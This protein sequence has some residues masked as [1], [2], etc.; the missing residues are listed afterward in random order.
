[1]IP[2]RGRISA[3]HQVLPRYSPRDAIGSE[4][5]LIQALLKKNGIGGEIFYDEG[6]DHEISRPLDHLKPADDQS[7]IC[8]Y[9]FSVGS[10][11]PFKLLELRYRIWSR[12]HN[13]TPGYFFNKP[14]ERPAQTACNLGRRQIPIVS[15]LSEVVLADSAFNLS[16]MAGHTSAKTSVIPV[17]RDYDLLLGKARQSQKFIKDDGKKNI[18]FVGR[19]C[20]NKAQHDLIELIGLDKKFGTKNTRLILVGSFYSHD[21]RDAITSF[22]RDLELKVSLGSQIDW[23]ADVIIPGSISDDEMAACY[24][25]ADVFVSLS[26]HEGF[27]VPLVEAMN[28]GLPI[29]AHNSTAVTE[30][31][32]AGGLMVDKSDKLGLMHSLG[33]IVNDQAQRSELK[34]KGLARA[35]ELSLESAST[36][37]MTFIRQFG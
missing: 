30:T 24:R 15:L 35:K 31:V 32:G 14:L 36:K 8:L 9:H 7:A 16:E 12:Y 23:S 19:I 27:G 33:R 6:G 10:A 17:F 2:A 25:D 28:F 34:D 11:I 26:D 1:M 13:I 5:L 22:A 18:L 21:F 29:L 37:L 20:P 3:I 4:V